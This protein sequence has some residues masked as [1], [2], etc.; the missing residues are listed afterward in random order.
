[1]AFRQSQ[2]GGGFKERVRLHSHLSS[3]DIAQKIYY[4]LTLYLLNSYTLVLPLL[5]T[6]H[7]PALLFHSNLRNLWATI[8]FSYLMM[9]TI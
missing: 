8:V 9:S 4:F 6:Q 1:M 3:L 5:A 2:R 7:H